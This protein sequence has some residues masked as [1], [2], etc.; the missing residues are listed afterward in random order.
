LDVN[1]I[2]RN[3]AAHDPRS[4]KL[5]SASAQEG[6]T[7]C[8]C[9]QLKFVLKVE[10]TVPWTKA[11]DLRLLGNTYRLQTLK[12]RKFSGVSLVKKEVFLGSSSPKHPSARLSDTACDG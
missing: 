3:V 10:H 6:T 12:E 9:R 1:L 8:V 2:L 4:I 7:K 5:S 11:R